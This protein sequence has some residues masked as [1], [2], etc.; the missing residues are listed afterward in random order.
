MNWDLSAI[1]RDELAGIRSFLQRRDD[2]TPDARAALACRLSE[3]VAAKVAG[4]PPD[5]DDE[6][7]LELVAAR[8]AARG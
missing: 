7:F 3:A 8:K 4:A 1:S 5:R 2:L 6:R